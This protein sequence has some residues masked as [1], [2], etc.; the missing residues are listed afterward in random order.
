MAPPK[1]PRPPA[2]QPYPGNDPVPRAESLGSQA[3]AAAR[4]AAAFY[5]GWR[6]GKVVAPSPLELEQERQSARHTTALAEYRSRL[7]GFRRRMVA[8]TAGVVGGA[9]IAASTLDSLPADASLAVLGGSAV[10]L[11]A[12]QAVKGSRGAKE[13][14]EP[15]PPPQI[16]PAPLPLPPGSPG[17]D[18]A[19]RVT[20]Y[21][22]HIMELLPA[23]EPLHEQAAE[24]IL[25]AD[26]ATAPGLNALI[27][28]IRSMERISAE[29]P[30]SAAAASAQLT[31]SALLIRLDEGAAAYQELLESVIALSSAPALTG[32]PSATLRPAI[33]DMHAYAE[34]LRR[35]AQTWL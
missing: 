29:L 30:G 35:A 12:W 24:Q 33:Q 11:G 5:R 26:A 20:G 32:G 31:V 22:M 7:A 9:A 4:A 2:R 21:R 17:V 27:E 15:V 10:V 8:G 13:L 19:L 34:G 14:R 28:R 3:A 25:A 6:S 23:I 18:A 1:G 16:A